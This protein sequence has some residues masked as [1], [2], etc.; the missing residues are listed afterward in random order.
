MRG[1]DNETRVCWD[2]CSGMNDDG[3]EDRPKERYWRT[4]GLSVGIGIAALASIIIATLMY[5]RYRV[6]VSESEPEP[7]PTPTIEELRRQFDD[8]ANLRPSTMSN[9]TAAS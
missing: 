3:K 1:E 7:E 8:L 4:V 9:G 6:K 2:K 5:R